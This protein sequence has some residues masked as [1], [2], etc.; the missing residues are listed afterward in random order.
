MPLFGLGKKRGLRATPHE[1]LADG[2]TEAMAVLGVA[3]RQDWAALRALLSR[4]EGQ[5]LTSMT[6]RLHETPGGVDRLTKE[7]EAA[8][9]DALAL[10]VLGQFSIEAAWKVRTGKRAQHVSQDQFKTFHE[11]LRVAEEQLYTSIELDPTS[12][13]PWCSLMASGRGLQ[14]GLDTVRRRL[15]AVTTRSPGHY[16]AHSHMLQQLC[17]K[18]SGSHEQM[19]AFALE[20]MRGPHGGLLA[21]LVPRAQYEHLADLPKDSKERGFIRSAEYRAQ[22]QE[23][24]D[25]SIFQPGFVNARSPYR[26]ANLFG[27]VF[28]AAG[29]WPQAR[30]AFALTDGVVVNWAQ[31]PNPVALY[32]RQRTL[33]VS[34]S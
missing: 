1:L 16:T 30:E 17:R 29:M 28:C 33:A 20:S 26:A 25:R 15:E 4:Y 18:W 11:M 32:S 19:H 13:A 24:A 6:V 3:G 34:K 23:A 21:E 27:W 12:A 14:V 31:F 5:D 9:D 8:T 22:L 2:D 10:A 7:L